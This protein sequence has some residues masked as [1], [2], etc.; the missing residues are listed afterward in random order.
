MQASLMEEELTAERGQQLLF[1]A[2]C[3]LAEVFHSNKGS[4]TQAPFMIIEDLYNTI[5]KETSH[6]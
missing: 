4:L 5:G 2:Y 3:Y 6:V 1:D